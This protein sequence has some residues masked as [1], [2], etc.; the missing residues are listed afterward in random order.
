MT[1]TNSHNRLRKVCIGVS[2]SIALAASSIGMFD[3]SNTAFAAT[4]STTKSVARQTTADQ[5]I[6]TGL[7]LQGVPYEFGAEAGRSSSFDCSSFTQYIFAQNNITLPRSSTQQSTAGTFVA[8]SQ[9]QPGDLVFFYSPIHHVA[10]Y[11]GDGKI[12][13]TFGEGGVT[14]TD[15]NAGWWDE[16]YTTA[17]HVLSV[18]AN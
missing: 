17:R 6:A 9:L 5:I 13:H 10:V 2:L 11:I 12:L 3:N 15:L 14:V 4:A 16:H 1:T 7:R 18:S 8:R